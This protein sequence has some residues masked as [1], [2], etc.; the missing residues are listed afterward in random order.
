MTPPPPTVPCGKAT[1]QGSHGREDHPRARGAPQGRNLRS[2]RPLEREEQEHEL[3]VREVQ[4]LRVQVVPAFRDEV[5]ASALV[6][7]RTSTVVLL[8]SIVCELL[9]VVTRCSGR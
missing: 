9:K 2:D 5:Q 1:H 8:V 6:A 3:N 7:S 4:P